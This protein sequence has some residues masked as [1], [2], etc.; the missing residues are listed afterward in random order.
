MTKRTLAGIGL[1]ANLGEKETTLLAAWRNLRAFPQIHPLAISSPYRSAPLDMD[2]SNTFVN[3]VALAETALQPLEL[4]HVL[5]Q[6]ELHH[7]RK[8]TANTTG[9]QDR[10]LDLDLLFFG[11]L[12]QQS[13]ALTLPHPRLHERLFVLAP[14]AELLPHWRHPVSGHNIHTMVDHLLSS[15]KQQITRIEWSH[16]PDCCPGEQMLNRS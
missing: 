14:L 11:D 15:G 1:G 13:T 12:C 10:H 4:L 9:Y 7:G 6:L 16:S 5:L 3:A 2:S 8:R